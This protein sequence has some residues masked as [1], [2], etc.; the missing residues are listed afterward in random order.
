MVPF[1]W[2]WPL[3]LEWEEVPEDLLIMPY[4]PIKMAKS[5]ENVI[6]SRTM[7]RKNKQAKMEKFCLPRRK[8]R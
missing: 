7:N 6:G 5:F 1:H 3:H 2:Q 8:N 4:N